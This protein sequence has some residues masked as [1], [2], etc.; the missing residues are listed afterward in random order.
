MEMDKNTA[1]NRVNMESSWN[2]TAKLSKKHLARKTE[3]NKR[4]ISRTRK[5]QS[6]SSSRSKS[7]R[8]TSGHETEKRWNEMRRNGRRTPPNVIPRPAPRWTSAEWDAAE[9]APDWR[10]HH[11][12][13]KEAAAEP[14]RNRNRPNQLERGHRRAAAERVNAEEMKWQRNAVGARLEPSTRAPVWTK[15]RRKNKSRDGE[16]AHQQY[17][18]GTR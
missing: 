15:D 5:K 4:T 2:E 17:A 3:T 7:S 16:T 9:V 1:E 13:K 8:A 14:I 10:L 12:R 6:K 11:P 18:R